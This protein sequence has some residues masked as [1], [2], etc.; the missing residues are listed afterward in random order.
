MGLF[1]KSS[2]W[3]F[4]KNSLWGKAKKAL[5]AKAAA[6]EKSFRNPYSTDLLDEYGDVSSEQNQ[7][8]LNLAQNKSADSFAGAIR[9]VSPATAGTGI[10]AQNII[11]TGQAGQDSAYSNWQQQMAQKQGEAEQSKAQAIISNEKFNQERRM[12]EDKARVKNN[13]GRKSAWGGLLGKAAGWAASTFLSEQAAKENIQYQ[14]QSP[15]GHNIY[16]FNYKGDPGNTYQGTMAHE[17]S[18]KKPEAI[19]DVGGK[20]WVNYSLL[21]IA[22]RKVK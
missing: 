18:Y 3:W 21:D 13:P 16:N 7:N 17:V 12:E 14:G 2:S 4:G 10:M 8:L 6:K 20:K 22:H 11:D 1:G 19:V 15:K 9:N 5:S